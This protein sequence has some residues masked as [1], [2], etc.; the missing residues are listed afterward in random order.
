MTKKRR[1]ETTNLKGSIFWQGR[2]PLRLS[3]RLSPFA[4]LLWVLGAKSVMA[5]VKA[6][7]D[8][9]T[10]AVVQVR[11]ESYS[12]L[13]NVQVR[14]FSLRV[15]EKKSGKSTTLIFGGAERDIGTD[16]EIESL[17]IVADYLIAI[18]RLHIGIFDLRTGKEKKFILC[19]Y[20]SISPNGQWVAYK[21]FQPRFIPPESITDVVVVLD[22]TSLDSKPVFPEPEKISVV[23]GRVLAWE[24]DPLKRDHGGQFFWSPN[25]L[26]FIFFA[27]CP[28]SK[29]DSEVSGAPYYVEV[30]LSKGLTDIRFQ[31]VAI[32]QDAY[33][34]PTVEVKSNRVL[35]L[36][37][38]VRWIDEK[39][40]EITLP[41]EDVWAKR[42]VILN[43]PKDIGQERKGEESNHQYNC[44]R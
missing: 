23:D 41:E 32:H 24:P 28:S 15:T 38:S 20:P 5:D 18:T 1:A 21:A 39:S 12:Q 31:R 19:L 22:M 17:R 29:I 3:K 44:G 42:P 33:L 4:L 35:F 30:D 36:P 16:E 8:L 2:W 7:T 26:R 11:E 40:I 13:K 25:D 34:K 6:T 43:L 9:Y 37:Q 10:V 27:H 14:E